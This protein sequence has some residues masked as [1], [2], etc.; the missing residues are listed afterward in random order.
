MELKLDDPWFMLV[1]SRVKTIEGRLRK[2]KFVDV[3]PGMELEILSKRGDAIRAH[4]VA[5]RHYSSFREYLLQEGL[6]RTLPG[7]L[8]L[9]DGVEVYRRYYSQ[10]LDE[11]CGVVAMEMLLIV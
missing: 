7:V 4:I 9:D 5:I 6:E 1:E 3:A 8:S 11:I 10:G 2:G